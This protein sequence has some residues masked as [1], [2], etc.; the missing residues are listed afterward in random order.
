MLNFVLCD[1]N[2]VILNKLEQMLSKLLLKNDYDAQIGFK[3]DNVDEILSYIKTHKVNVLFLD[4]N[5]QSNVSGIDLANQIRKIDK[6]VYI[7]FTTAHLEYALLAYK[8]KTFDYLAK[9]ITME[10]LQDTLDRLFNDLYYKPKQYLTLNNKNIINQND[11][12]YIRKDGMKLI[13]CTSNKRY[14]TYS[15]FNKIQPSL[16]EN[17]VRC[18]KSYIANIN[19]I[20]NVESST[21]TVEFSSG[22]CYI[23][24]KYKNNFMEVLNNYGIISNNGNSINYAQSGVN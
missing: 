16:P 24:P 23:G 1:D 17:F 20:I 5:L 14:E 7:I 9:P 2:V 22:K 10:R 8:V 3:S 13:I 19:N 11:I 4:I 6:E 18:H 21:N 15:S 12:Q